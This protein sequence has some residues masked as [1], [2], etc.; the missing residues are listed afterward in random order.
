MAGPQALE[1][2][3]T[4][5]QLLGVRPAGALDLLHPHHVI[6]FQNADQRGQHRLGDEPQSDPYTPGAQ[7]PRRPD[8]PFQPIDA[9]GV[10][11]EHARGR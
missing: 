3:Q 6:V 2:L 8:L 10:V 4:A 7:P 5:V 9:L 1:Q 11:Q